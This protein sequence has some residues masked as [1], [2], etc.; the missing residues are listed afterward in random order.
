MTYVYW[1]VHRCDNWRIWDQLDVT[2]Y[3][4][5]SLL[6]C[7]TCFGHSYIHHQKPAT[8][9]L[10]PATRKLPQPNH[11][12]TST[13]I[14]TRTHDHCGDT[15]EKSQAPDDG[16]INVRNMLSIEE[17]KW[18]LITR[19]IKLVSYSPTRNSITV[20]WN[21]TRNRS[22]LSKLQ[23]ACRSRQSYPRSPKLQHTKLLNS[24]LSSFI[25]TGPAVF[26]NTHNRWNPGKKSFASMIC[27]C[28]Y[29]HY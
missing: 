11:T 26:T 9:R 12:E 20:P 5:I 3:Y 23:V 19:D 17:V 1:T 7:S 8:S 2:S 10:K 14:E 22:E 29:R 15:I 21:K 6:L 4:F 28:S 18:N 25:D 27:C 24:H 16:C 13:N